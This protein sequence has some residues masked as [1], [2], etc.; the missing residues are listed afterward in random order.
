MQELF[1]D[2]SEA[3]ANW[4]P[5]AES[6][7][8]GKSEQYSV[9]KAAP[10]GQSSKATSDTPPMEISKGADGKA[11]F[12]PLSLSRALLDGIDAGS[13]LGL[14]S[15]HVSDLPEPA[16]SVLSTACDLTK[17]A[18]K[19]SSESESGETNPLHPS[20]QE[21]A[22][23]EAT[24]NSDPAREESAPTIALPQEPSQRRSH[25]PRE[26][27]KMLETSSP[28]FTALDAWAGCCSPRSGMNSNR[29]VRFLQ[30][31][32]LEKDKDIALE[33]GVLIHY[34]YSQHQ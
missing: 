17:V 20:M 2:V 11:Q 9:S 22:V 13:I 18:V 4:R 29:V 5:T 33:V 19:S 30:P 1:L 10:D 14:L 3:V 23:K 7:D 8:G 6:D 26:E 32:V 24:Y 25:S 27:R 31:A 12:S 28:L 15:S 21:D 34:F 16:S